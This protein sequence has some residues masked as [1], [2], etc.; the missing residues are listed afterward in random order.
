MIYDDRDHRLRA[1]RRWPLALRLLADR[2]LR[3]HVIDTTR[4]HFLTRSHVHAHAFRTS[5]GSCLAVLERVENRWSERAADAASRGPTQACSRL[6]TTFLRAQSRFEHARHQQ[7]VCSDLLP[8]CPAAPVTLLVASARPSAAGDHGLSL[9]A[10]SRQA[11]HLGRVGRDGSTS[12]V[13]LSD[14][15]GGRSH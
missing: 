12:A 2:V 15:R 1:R 5:P 9:P 13:C 7:T 10:T 3:H 4:A 8:R 11:P 14:R 6:G